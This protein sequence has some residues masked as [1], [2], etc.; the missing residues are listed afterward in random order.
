MYEVSGFDHMNAKVD[1]LTQ[2]INNLTITPTSTIVA[3][4]PNCEIYGVQGHVTID[5]QLLFEPTHDQ[6]N[7]VQGN[8]YSNTYNPGWRNHPNFSYRNNNALFAYSH[9]PLTPPGSKTI[10]EPMLLLMHPKCLIWNL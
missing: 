10:K 2:K 9:A 8:P 3:V 6:E 4:T 1:V 7:Y 5:Y